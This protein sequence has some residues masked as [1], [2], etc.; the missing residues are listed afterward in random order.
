MQKANGDL[1]ASSPELYDL[2]EWALKSLDK[3]NRSPV[4]WNNDED[5]KKHYE[6]LAL[7]K[8]LDGGLT[9]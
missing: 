3:A 4:D 6:A 5:T 1:A 7:I 8:R 9:I 2:L